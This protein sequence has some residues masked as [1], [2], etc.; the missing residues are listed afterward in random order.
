MTAEQIVALV[1]SGRQGELWEAFGTDYDGF[2]VC[3][4]CLRARTFDPLE[5]CRR[6]RE[7]L[8]DA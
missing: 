1:S 5:T 3:W 4:R 7:E 2:G 6:C 8:V